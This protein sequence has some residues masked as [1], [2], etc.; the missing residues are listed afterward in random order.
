MC[1]VRFLWRNSCLIHLFQQ[2]RFVFLSRD[3]PAY[4]I[5]TL[6]YLYYTITGAA[7]VV[8]VG[9][10][11]SFI[12]G[13]QRNTLPLVRLKEAFTRSLVQLI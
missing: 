6:S 2:S 8:V 11:F 12:S 13:T 5:Y 1:F 10:I 9:L 7:V 3:I 4:D